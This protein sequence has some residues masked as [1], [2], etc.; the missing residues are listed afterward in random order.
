MSFQITEIV[1]YGPVEEPRVLALRPGEL[2]IITGRSRTG[3]S[4]LISI[5]DYC[6][7]AGECGVAFGPIRSTVEWYALRLRAGTTEVFVA[8]KA[9]AKGKKTTNVTHLEVS[10]RVEIP[11][12]SKLSPSTNI[13]SAVQVLT[14]L[15][16]IADNIHEPPPG[17]SRDALRAN[18]KHALY[19]CFQPQD[20]INNRKNL[21]YQQ[22]EQFIPQT[23]RDVLPYFLGAIDDDHLAKI[24][25]VRDLRREIRLAERD[26]REI[27]ALRGQGHARATNLLREAVDLGLTDA[28][29]RELEFDE[30]V[31]RLR[32]VLDRKVAPPKPAL[33]GDQGHYEE[34]LRRRDELTRR[35][36]RIDADLRGARALVAERSGY[37]TETSEQVGRLRSLELV[38][39]QEGGHHACPLCASPLPDMPDD[40]ELRKALAGAEERLRNV[41]QD[42][43]HLERLIAELEA[44]LTAESESLSEVRGALNALERSRREVAA[45]NDQAARWA[46]VRGRISIY[47]EAAPESTSK[48]AGTDKLRQRIDVLKRR[49]TKLEAELSQESVEE[50]VASAVSVI[51]SYMTDSARRLRLEHSQFPLRFDT[52][53]LTVVADTPGEAVPMD[54]MGAGENWVGYHIAAHLALH[55]LFAET[56]R[57]VP[58]FLFLDQPSQVYFPADRDVEGKLE[59]GRDGRPIDEDRAAVLR[60][61]ELLRDAVAQLGGEVQIV[62]TEHA[63]PAVDWY[64]DAVRERWRGG[65]ALIPAAG[66]EPE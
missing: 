37:K 60:M 33:G 30:L 18:L 15:A 7:G 23:I 56:G 5:V 22:D 41:D 63:D 28:P 46:H 59:V 62:V 64:Q 58:R 26:L 39:E 48:D 52:N 8:R 10:G 66:I 29:E 42:N 40:D 65:N 34:L 38:P 49:L 3:K 4:S 50:R 36:R 6:L 55:R 20:Q 43:P 16:G 13:E 14:R 57:P 32:A 2:N 35:V 61:F 44:G 12:K 17:H 9:P 53:R 31:S 47:L 11:P 27:E 19:F 24:S 25:R 51:S 1:L 21:F 54:K 45:Y